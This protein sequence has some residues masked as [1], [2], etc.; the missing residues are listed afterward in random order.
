MLPLLSSKAM[1]ILLQELKFLYNYLERNWEEEKGWRVEVF[2][3]SGTK[4][5]YCY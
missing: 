4:Q 3:M 1:E 5:C 2:G